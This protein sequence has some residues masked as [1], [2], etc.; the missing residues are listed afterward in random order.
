MVRPKAEGELRARRT[1]QSTYVVA[2]SWMGLM[3]HVH[4][5]LRESLPDKIMKDLNLEC[6]H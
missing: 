3:L 1:D 6:L 4:L 2:R 5:M